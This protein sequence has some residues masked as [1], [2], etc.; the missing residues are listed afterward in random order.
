MVEPFPII[1]GLI[2]VL[3]L[4]KTFGSGLVGNSYRPRPRPLAVR[5]ICGLIGLGLLAGMGIGTWRDFH[6]SY[7]VNEHQ[8]S[9]T[10]QVPARPLPV[11]PKSFV[12]YKDG[13]ALIHFVFVDDTVEPAVPVYVKAFAVDWPRDK[14]KQ[15]ADKF[16]AGTLKVKYSFCLNLVRLQPSGDNSSSLLTMGGVDLGWGRNGISAAASGNLHAA[17][18]SGGYLINLGYGVMDKSP[19]SLVRYSPQRLQVLVFVNPLAGDDPLRAINLGAFAALYK[20]KMTKAVQYQRYP[21][22]YPKYIFVALAWYLGASAVVLLAATGFL[23]QVFVRRQLAFAGVMAGILF[24]VAGLDRMMLKAHFA[25]LNDAKAS[26]RSRLLGC[27]QMQNTFFYRHTAAKELA[28]ILD[29]G[30]TP[31]AVSDMARLIK[32]RLEEG[33]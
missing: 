15:F 13:R 12:D 23:A 7:Q 3:I 17:Y 19:F 11:L 33:L 9:L 14:D 27:R 25:R 16:T 6:E 24:F 10:V 32:L 30:H 20:N 8:Q 1:F 31:Q 26:V 2:F 22:Y 29:D 21:V 18:C 5:I 28:T 4:L